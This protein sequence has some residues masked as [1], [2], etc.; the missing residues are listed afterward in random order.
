ME[1]PKG[2]TGPKLRDKLHQRTE[3]VTS[4]VLERNID[5]ASPHVGQGPAVPHAP[6]QLVTM[7]RIKTLEEMRRVMKHP[8]VTQFRP[9]WMSLRLFQPSCALIC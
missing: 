7:L 2:A 6:F 3:G 1:E 9:V 8:C 5:P 4:R